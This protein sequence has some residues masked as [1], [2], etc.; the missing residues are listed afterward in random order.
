MISRRSSVQIW[1]PL[2][3][4]ASDQQKCLIRGPCFSLSR[5]SKCTQ[6]YTHALHHQPYCHEVRP[7][8]LPRIRTGL[9][10]LMLTPE[11]A[12]RADLREGCRYGKA[13]EV[14]AGVPPGGCCAGA[15]Y[16]SSDRARG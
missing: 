13:E 11:M 15:G 12:G 10:L 4:R 14:Y 7:T 1:P 5:R 16:G 9:T 3:R 8:T 6:K 2:R